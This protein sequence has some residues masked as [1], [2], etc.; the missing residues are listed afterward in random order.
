MFFQTG[1]NFG[2]NTSPSNFEVIAHARQEL[3]K[4]LW[5][6]QRDVVHQALPHLPKITMAHAPTP[7]EIASF[8]RVTPDDLNPGVFDSDGNRLPPPYTHHVDDVMYAD[9][10]MHMLRAVACS[11]IALYVLLGFP[12]PEIPNAMSQDK[13]NPLYNHLR[14]HVGYSVNSRSLEVQLLPHKKDRI[15]ETLQRWLIKTS[16]NLADAAAL[17][18]TLESMSRYNLWGRVWFFNLHNAIRVGL[19]RQYHIWLCLH[20]KNKKTAWLRSQ[21]P[22]QLWTRIKSIISKDMAQ[23][24]WAKNVAVPMVNDVRDCI[25]T[26]LAAFLDPTITW[27]AKI[28]FIVPRTPHAISVGDA[29]FLGGGGHCHKLHFWFDVIWSDAIKAA[30]LSKQVHINYLEF[31]VL[32]IQLAGLIVRFQTHA[33]DQ[34][35]VGLIL[36]DNMVSMSWATRLTS[37][38]L[39]GQ[40]LLYIFAELLRLSNVGVNS[41]HIPGEINLLAD[42]I[43]RPTHPNLSPAER[44]EQIFQKHSFMRTW[45]Y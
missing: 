5:L 35:P 3:A 44:C 16:Y 28:P 17:V 18:G 23:F 20:G 24:M 12:R 39:Q 14:V 22:K 4:W 11:A 6:H 9:I 1:T 34:F 43:S 38:S 45:G 36:T 15:I 13:I 7:G 41:K 37:K 21:L 33:L 10:Q 8:A 42:F 40:Y 32:I 30:I 31:I 29:S 19:P 2:G 27:A 25:T 26:L